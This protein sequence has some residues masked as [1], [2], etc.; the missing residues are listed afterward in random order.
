MLGTNFQHS[1]VKDAFE[2]ILCSIDRL[3]EYSHSLDSDETVIKEEINSI[4]WKLNNLLLVA[5]ACELSDAV[6]LVL[7]EI[8]R[9]PK[10]LKFFILTLNERS[11]DYSRTVDFLAKIKAKRA[12]FTAMKFQ[13]L[14]LCD[15]ILQ[16]ADEISAVE[17]IVSSS[18]A[19]YVKERA[20]T[21]AAR[22]IER[23][24]LQKEIAK[25]L[26]T[27]LK[28]QRKGKYG[29]K[30]NWIYEELSNEDRVLVL[31]CIGVTRLIDNPTVVGSLV[32]IY[33][34]LIRCGAI[35]EV[36]MYGRAD[37]SKAAIQSLVESEPHSFAKKLKK[38]DHNERK[39][40]QKYI[41]SIYG[42]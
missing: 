36:V 13:A 30:E 17:I 31:D 4:T 16:R 40:I 25:A 38:L 9:D 37:L 14:T 29:S 15:E 34:G 28:K 7:D 18:S 11:S 1:P 24:L 41:R 42:F 22:L 27:Q 12:F 23:P 32:K 6:S 35:R 3:T 26:L 20:V 39:Y 2:D 8:F 21:V 19:N 5:R 10:V 33:R